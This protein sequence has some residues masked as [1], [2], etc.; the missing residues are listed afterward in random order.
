MN[1]MDVTNVTI[2]MRGGPAIAAGFSL[3]PNV[4]L[5]SKIRVR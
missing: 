3:V 2:V 4:W 1:V 5:T